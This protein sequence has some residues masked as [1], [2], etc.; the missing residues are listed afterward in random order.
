MLLLFFLSLSESFFG[1]ANGVYALWGELRGRGGGGRDL[2]RKNLRTASF[3]FK[4]INFEYGL[5]MSIIDFYSIFLN[6]EGHDNFF[7]KWIFL[8]L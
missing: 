8:C 6:F 2:E 5:V 1:I 7:K 3:F 4:I